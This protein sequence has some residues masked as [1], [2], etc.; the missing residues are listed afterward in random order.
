MEK[1]SARVLK[2]TTSFNPPS[3]PVGWILLSASL[4]SKVGNRE[5]KSVSC[6]KTAPLV[7]DEARISGHKCSLPTAPARAGYVGIQSH[8]QNSTPWIRPLVGVQE[9]L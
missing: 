7:C 4:Y 1:K 6:P 5:A 9:A 8:N 3:C 2:H